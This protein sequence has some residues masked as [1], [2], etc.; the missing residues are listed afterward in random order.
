[1]WRDTSCSTPARFVLS[2]V[3][4]RKVEILFLVRTI[5]AS[6][7]L[8]PPLLGLFCAH[9]GRVSNLKASLVLLFSG[10]DISPDI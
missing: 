9:P 2:V 3:T 1:V 4:F 5:L 10:A 7:S 8:D 6:F